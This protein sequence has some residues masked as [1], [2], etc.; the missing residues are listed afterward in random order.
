MSEKILATL[1]AAL[2]VASFAVADETRPSLAGAW[3]SEAWSTEGWPLDPPYTD[4]GR[5]A[6]EAWAAAPENDPSQRCI[7]PLGRII[8]APMPHEIIQEP[9]RIVMLYEYEHQV[10]RVYLD[11]RGHPPDAYATLMGHSTGHWDG[12]TLVVDTVDME[13]GY[14][15]PQGLPYSGRL[16]LV[17]RYG[18]LDG[19][20]RMQAELVIDDPEYYE[21]PWT[22]VKRYRRLAGEIMDYECI[23][24]PH[25]APE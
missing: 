17:E 10:R 11:G 15:R 9:Q 25:V 19:G 21:E 14:F 13:P 1:A 5:A 4:A 6:Q 7:I 16:R 23:V 12:D 22:V 8:S 20:E 2:T 24:R 3:E 18:L